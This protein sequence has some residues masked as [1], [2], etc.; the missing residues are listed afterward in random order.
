MFSGWSTFYTLLG[1]ASAALVGLLFVVATLTSTADRERRARGQSLFLTPT[2]F[3]FG[4]VLTLSA[5]ALAPGLAPATSR[6]LAAGV[7]L[8]GVLNLGGV[9]AGIVR[10]KGALTVHWSDPW[11]Y[12]LVPT[13]LFAAIAVCPALPDPAAA[14][15]GV[16][17]AAASLVLLA[18]RNAWDL[19]T[20]LAGQAGAADRASGENR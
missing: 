9:S 10:R 1:E 7:G 12:G 8:V 3:K 13:L 17:A 2:V 19:V 14:A 5:I 11:C 6:A 16:G 4:S 20:T 18:I 15:R